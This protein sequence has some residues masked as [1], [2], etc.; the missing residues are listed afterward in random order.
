MIFFPCAPTA[1]SA[2]NFPS[3]ETKQCYSPCDNAKEVKIGTQS[4]IERAIQFFPS[5]QTQS[6]LRRRLI[7]PHPSSLNFFHIRDDNRL[8]LFCGV[9]KQKLI[10][11]QVDKSGVNHA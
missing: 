5:E 2:V 10:K 3:D 11:L 1:L 6:S 4:W 9:Y 7:S 8:I